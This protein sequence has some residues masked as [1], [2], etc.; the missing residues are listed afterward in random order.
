VVV[1]IP[2]QEDIVENIPCFLLFEQLA[3]ESAPGNQLTHGL[4]TNSNVG[5]VIR[6]PFAPIY[7]IMSPVKRRYS[8]GTRSIMT[9]IWLLEIPSIHCVNVIL[10][11]RR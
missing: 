8:L 3:G 7:V 5:A 11:D 1:K 10:Y 4:C 9:E 2:L 6:Y